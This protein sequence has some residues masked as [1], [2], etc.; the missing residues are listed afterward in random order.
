MARLIKLIGLASVYL[1]M[2]PCTNTGNGLSMLPNEWINLPNLVGNLLKG[3][4]T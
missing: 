1:M 4:G 2:A 3:V